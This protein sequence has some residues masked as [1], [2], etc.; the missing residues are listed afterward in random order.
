MKNKKRAGFIIGGATVL[1]AAAIAG[2]GIYANAAMKVSSF[3][4]GRNDLSQEIELNGNVAS[5]LSQTFYAGAAGK[6]KTVHVKVGDS[7]KKGDLLVSFDEERIDYLIALAELDA[8]SVSG[9]Y[10]NTIE[11]GNRTQAL[12]NEA[13]INL[14][15]L[16]QQITDTQ[17]QILDL[18]KRIAD[19]KAAYAGEGAALQKSIIDTNEKIAEADEKD[20]TDYEAQL[21]NLQKLAQGSAYNQQYDS[22]ILKMQEEL[23][24]LSADLAHYKE[25]KAEMTSQKAST[26]TARITAGQKEQLEAMKAV[27]ELTTEETIKNLEAAKEGIRAEFDGIVTAISVEEGEEIA[28]GMSLVTLASSDDII[29]KC[30]VNKYDILSIE[31][32][33]I[34]SSKIGNT[35]YTG[36]VTRIE[37]ITGADAGTTPGVGVEVK[38]D[39]P[40]DSII[41]G[42]DTKTKVNV[43]AV[44]DKLCIPRSAAVEEDGKTY[45]FVEKEKKAVRKTIETGVK[46]DDMIEVTSGLNE[47]EVVVWNEET[48]IKDGMDIRISQ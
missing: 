21:A 4:V 13:T 7:V 16:N 3:T 30:T 5:E 10:S 24:R 46:N 34:T 31:E 12:Y 19:K 44:E 25:Y 42:L 17:N 41:L 26:A 29:V 22:D 27:S 18:E 2:V 40:D 20:D 11:M 15:V 39:N 9:N 36:K 48:E 35:E 23:N 38:L 47:G 1:C 33:Q 6:V 28:N 32:G 45:V 14:G 8:Q 43:A 37:K